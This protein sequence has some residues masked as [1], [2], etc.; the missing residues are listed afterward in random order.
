MSSYLA[1]KYSDL[2][3]VEDTL[4][5]FKMLAE[6]YG[7]I[8]E[9][10]RACGIARR[11]AYLWT[12]S[13]YVKPQTKKKIVEALLEAEPEQILPYIAKRSVNQSAEVLITS[14]FSV[15]EKAVEQTERNKFLEF[16]N[17]F[18]QIKVEN[19]G[20]I[21]DKLQREVS[22]MVI[23]MSRDAADKGV[24]WSP[25][26]LEVFKAE[27]LEVI[28]PMVTREIL[29]KG[30]D[31]ASSIAAQLSLPKIL[32]S[33]IIGALTE[34]ETRNLAYERIQQQDTFSTTPPQ[35][36][37]PH[38][39]T[40]IAASEPVRGIITHTEVRASVSLKEQTTLQTGYSLSVAQLAMA[41]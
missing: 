31:K 18:D 19:S 27:Q 34:I 35:R 25:K 12:T 28:I 5:L 23:Q 1:E 17:L 3:S 38:L 36:A 2:L 37:I 11:T 8:S 39:T 32:V 14:L 41:T 15:Y 7:G 24:N 26:P 9:A 13:N 33:G 20:L 6:T 22:D 21:A 40:S 29:A 16:A 4:V 10:A 30:Q